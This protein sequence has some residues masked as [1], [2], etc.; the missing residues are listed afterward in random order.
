MTETMWPEIHVA[1]MKKREL[2]AALTKGAVPDPDDEELQKTPA[3]VI[4]LL[5]FDPLDISAGRESDANT[6]TDKG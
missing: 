2:A 3:D 6:K 5:G 1:G 4:L